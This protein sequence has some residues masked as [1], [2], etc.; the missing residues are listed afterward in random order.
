MDV[1]PGESG[2][3]VKEAEAKSGGILDQVLGEQPSLI[4]P[5]MLKVSDW[6][7]RVCPSQGKGPGPSVIVKCF[8]PRHLTSRH[9]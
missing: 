3:G 6:G 9:F 5:G 2:K 4:Q 1:F 8:P 7:P